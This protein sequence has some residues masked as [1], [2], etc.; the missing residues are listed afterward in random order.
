LLQERPSVH[1]K[2]ETV[3]P[4][5][6]I[7]SEIK[8]GDRTEKIRTKDVSTSSKYQGLKTKGG[9][10]PKKRKGIRYF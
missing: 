9:G 1:G 4:P 10:G 6:L 3:G 2:C 5:S 7:G 8:V